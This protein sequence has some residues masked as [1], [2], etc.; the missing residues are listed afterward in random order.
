MMS[1]CLPALLLIPFFA[2]LI[3]CSSGSPPRPA[4]I[5]T[6]DVPDSKY[7]SPCGGFFETAVAVGLQQL[8]ALPQIDLWFEESVTKEDR[9]RIRA[10]LVQVRSYLASHFAA[11][12]P[13]FTCFDVRSTVE[14]PAGSGQASSGRVLLVTTPSGWPDETEGAL[15]TVAAH[16]Y[17]HVWQLMLAGEDI[18]GLSPVWLLEGMAQWIAFRA[19]ADS[20][21][22]P[23]EDLSCRLEIPYG[24]L[25]PRLELLETR[26]GWRMTLPNYLTSLQAVNHLVTLSSPAA[27]HLYLVYLG[28]G[29]PWPEAFA[30]AFGLAAVDFY[31]EFDASNES[32]SD[33][34]VCPTGAG[35][36]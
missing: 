28:D 4:P 31:E 30:H 22:L 16:E 15:A 9:E 5:S 27:L 18:F 14:G 3:A 13:S 23:A 11:R 25:T 21:L 26:S 24:A 35:R 10:G 12:L 1:R 17:V 20:N 2:T 36:H 32:G 34:S 8:E 7:A 19:L 33:A 29:A 6:T